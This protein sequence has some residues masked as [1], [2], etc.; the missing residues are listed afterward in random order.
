[1]KDKFCYDDACTYV[2]HMFCIVFLLSDNSNNLYLH[3]HVNNKTFF[4][5]RMAADSDDGLDDL[6]DGDDDGN[7][8][9]DQLDPIFRDIMAESLNDNSKR[10]S[11]DLDIELK[12]SELVFYFYPFNPLEEILSDE[13]NFCTPITFNNPL[14]A[15]VTK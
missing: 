5:E 9:K 3:V 15:C 1:V 6:L 13:N 7:E 8:K 4:P 2:K 12:S 14:K 11:L 10:L